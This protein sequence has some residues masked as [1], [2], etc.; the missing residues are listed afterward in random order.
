[1]DCSLPSSSLCGIRQAKY[2]RGLLFP[3]PGTLPEIRI[4]PGSPALQADSFLPASPGKSSVD[5]ILLGN[6][7]I[8]PGFYTQEGHTL[9]SIHL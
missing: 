5:Q 4:E 8:E 2:W 1:M 3:S 6:G 9:L 7:V